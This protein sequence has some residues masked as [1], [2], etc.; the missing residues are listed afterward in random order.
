LGSNRA[1][2]GRGTGR[3]RE[4]TQGYETELTIAKDNWCFLL[5]RPFEELME[6]SSELSTEGK[7]C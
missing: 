4:S 7:T 6:S 3:E 5:P 2:Q 1:G